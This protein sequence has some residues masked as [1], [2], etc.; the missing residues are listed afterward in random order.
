[1]TTYTCRFWFAYN[2]THDTRIR[3]QRIDFKKKSERS[4]TFQ[5]LLQIVRHVTATNRSPISLERF[6]TSRHGNHESP[7]SLERFVTSRHGNQRI[8]YLLGT[9]RHITSRQSTNHLSPWN[10]SSHHVTKKIYFR[11]TICCVCTWTFQ[12]DYLVDKILLMP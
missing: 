4:F 12:L 9:V 11:M 3:A 1:M 5:L 8:T 10:G 7:I 2:I 6:V